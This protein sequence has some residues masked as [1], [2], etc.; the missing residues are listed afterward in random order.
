MALPGSV[1]INGMVL[2]GVTDE[3][4][5]WEF[6]PETINAALTPGRSTYGTEQRPGLPSTVT[7]KQLWVFSEV[8]IPVTQA[9]TF[10]NMVGNNSTV[11][12]SFTDNLW[13]TLI[14]GSSYSC[15]VRFLVE[16][17]AFL[18]KV[19][20]GDGVNQFSVSFTAWEI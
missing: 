3:N 14:F 20:N 11:T 9:A 8:L 2:D 1:S 19:Y 5:R 10:V 7:P 16:G 12:Y 4:C 6:Q 15:T 13:N 17:G 18:S